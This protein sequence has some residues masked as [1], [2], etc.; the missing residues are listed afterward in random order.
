M[1]KII[2][3]LLLFQSLAMTICD[4]PHDPPAYCLEYEVKQPAREIKK[5]VP[6]SCEYELKKFKYFRPPNT[7]HFD[8]NLNKVVLKKIVEVDLSNSKR[9]AA[10]NKLLS[11]NCK[12]PKEGKILVFLNCYDSQDNIADFRVLTRGLIEG[13]VF[14]T[15]S[16]QNLKFNCK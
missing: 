8:Q 13:S 5:Y 4:Y 12:L 9:I 11:N 3:L 6:Y 15:R 14:E 7:F 1:R 10:P 2:Y 16:Q